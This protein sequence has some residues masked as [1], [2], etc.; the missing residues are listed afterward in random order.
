MDETIVAKW[1]ELTAMAMDLDTVPKQ[2]TP[3]TLHNLF[4]RLVDLCAYQRI[5]VALRKD[6]DD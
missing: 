3:V 2:P 6:P 4:E 5:S 1:N